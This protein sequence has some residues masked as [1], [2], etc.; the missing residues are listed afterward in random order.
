MAQT[1]LQIEE[2]SVIFSVGR[3]PLFSISKLSFVGGSK[4]LVHGPSRVGKSTLMQIMA[5]LIPPT[6]GKIRYGSFELTR[7]TDHERT[8][9]RR[10][11]M[12]LIFPNSNLLPQLTVLENVL[13]SLPRF[14]SEEVRVR[15][16]LTEMKMADLV[17]RKASD[18][19]IGDQQRVALARV[20]LQNCGFVLAD[21]PTLGLDPSES[22]KFIQSLLGIG[23]QKT[24][25]VF[26]H[27]E[28]LKK[29]FQTVI[30][31]GELGA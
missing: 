25:V 8:Q 27:D 14:E 28:R 9:F 7:A 3:K 12:G 13:L 4:V 5:G 24:V 19:S 26:S 23:A 29:C 15:N 31:F 16:V 30:P 1:D 21:E 17:D 2:L 6:Q 11:K 18:L 22:E 10:Q 20:I